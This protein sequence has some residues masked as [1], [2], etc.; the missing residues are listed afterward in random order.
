M[1]SPVGNA[2][3]L[4]CT[5]IATLIAVLTYF[6]ARGPEK[7]LAVRV[8]SSSSLLKGDTSDVSQLKL[9]YGEE[10]V[11][12]PFRLS[13][14]IESTGR[15]PIQKNDIE[16]ELAIELKGS[17]V[18]R[19]WV[20]KA[21]PKSID[22]QVSHA[23]EKILVSHGLLNTGDLVFVE[24][25]TDGEPK[26]IDAYARIAGVKHVSLSRL[27]GAVQGPVAQP[28]F[29]V[30]GKGWEW[31]FLVYCSLV[32]V[33]CFGAISRDI[34]RRKTGHE[35]PS[36]RLLGALAFSL[37]NAPLFLMIAGAARSL[38]VN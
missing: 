3:A 8:L 12:A 26:S 37:C 14:V 2:L 36:A 9:L 7:A 15:A 29:L 23:G 13:V 35:S 31:G 17:R 32:W 38:L 5:I 34:L 30:H 27:D 22:C 18:L 33:G 24:I 6:A 20:S 28:F 19:A 10:S 11:F 1:R 21:T 25:L 4:G 16:Q